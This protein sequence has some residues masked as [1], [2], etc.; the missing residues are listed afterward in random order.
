MKTLF[1][2]AAA[3]AA[4]SATAAQAQDSDTNYS[5]FYVG[6]YVGGSK[7][8]DHGDETFRFDRD[9]NGEYDGTADAFPT[10]Q[11]G[12]SGG[13]AI[14]T[15]PGGRVEKDNGAAIAGARVGYDF[16][17]GNW[18]FG[19]LAEFEQN[20]V[21]DSASAFSNTPDNYVFNRRLDTMAAVRARVG[22]TWNG[23]LPYLTAGVAKGDVERSF[24]TSNT[25]NT[26][27]GG[28][29]REKLDGYQAGVG[30]EKKVGKVSV[31][32]EYLYTSLD[33]DDYV[34]RAAGGPAT[35]PFRTVN[36]AG[37]DITRSEDSF[38]IHAVRATAA[39]RF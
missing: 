22:Y 2:A 10:F 35:S 32:L 15:T 5:G 4:L 26:F 25:A 12:F 18:V 11:P 21:E 8:A 30:V 9:L 38:D 19:G 31:G 33:D 39:Y 6:G 29:A 7:A 36:T 28:A 20:N 16:Q 27:T 37:T 24:S 17:T 13:R 1:L 14:G 23:V 34:V 3:V